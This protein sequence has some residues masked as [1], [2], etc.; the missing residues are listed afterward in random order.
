MK[1]PHGDLP[2]ITWSV[3]G[4]QRLLQLLIFLLLAPLPV[5]FHLS[6]PSSAALPSFMFYLSCCC[7][8]YCSPSSRYCSFLLLM[9][10]L[11]PLL[12]LLRF[13][14]LPFI[15]SYSFSFSLHPCS[16]P[17]SFYSFP[18]SSLSLS[19]PSTLHF[20]LSL[21]RR[22]V[23]SMLPIVLKTSNIR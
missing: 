6:T 1:N 11:P 2:T 18:F 21:S 14:L 19:V 5:C 12:L 3:T 4:L 22:F 7:Y 17:C 20:S 10:L 13:L 8:S 9:V 16:C 15:L 23:S